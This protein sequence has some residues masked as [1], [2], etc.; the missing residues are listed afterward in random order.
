MLL[1]LDALHRFDSALPPLDLLLELRLL[2]VEYP[3]DYREHLLLPQ[4]LRVH[5]TSQVLGTVLYIIGQPNLQL[6]LAA[7]QL[8]VEARPLRSREGLCSCG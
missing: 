4:L 6:T 2:A 1:P 7:V 5:D 3:S 8:P